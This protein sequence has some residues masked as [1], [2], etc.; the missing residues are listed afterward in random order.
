MNVH[1]Q[2]LQHT[3]A[4]AALLE[5]FSRVSG[6]LPGTDAVQRLRKQAME[7]FRLRGLPHRRIEAWHYTDLRRLLSAVPEHE[8]GPAEG[9]RPPLIEG[10][11]VFGVVNGAA[12]WSTEVEGLSVAKLADRLAAGDETH[13]GGEPAADDL[14]GRV[15]RAFVSDGWVME[16][17]A[18]AGP[19][20]P[21]ELQILHGGGQTHTRC[22]FR[23]GAGAKATVIERQGGAENA[24]TTHVNRVE[25]EEGAELTWIV[26]QEQPDATTALSRFEGRIGRNARLSLFVMNAGGR[27][28]RY[29]IAVDA[30]GEDSD[31]QLRGV[32]L[33]SGQ[34]HTDVTMVLGHLGH[35]A[36]SREIVRNVVTG[37]ATG[38]FQG[39]IR[40]AREAQKTD[41]KMACN[42]LLLSDEGEF[43]TKPELEI[44]ADDVACGHGATV[45][46][47]DPAHLF[48]LMSRGV[49]E[50]EA[51]ALLIEAFLAEIVEELE[52]DILIE[53]LETRLH[54][55]FSRLN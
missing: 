41:A 24:F 48:Y 7:E 10:S 20:K 31:F 15:N 26:F 27:L 16:L 22:V 35:G 3:P 8:A 29:E 50:R 9:Q 55:W 4:E 21:L 47:I 6:G 1:T 23:A 37:K 5:S 53:A 32:N 46:E 43:H 42:T 38:V 54:A 44:F 45:T 34:S 25:V 19:R 13:L 33:L 51:R 36:T 40:V 14:I 39:Q 12:S 17:A 28:V 18:G 49:P 11:A 30:A 2:Q 52:D